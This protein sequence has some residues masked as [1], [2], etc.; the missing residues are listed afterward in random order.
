MITEAIEGKYPVSSNEVGRPLYQQELYGLLE[1]RKG[2]LV[3]YDWLL[4][5]MRIIEVF[6]SL[7]ADK[8]LVGAEVLEKIEEPDASVINLEFR[9]PVK[10][11]ILT[12]ELKYGD[13]VKK[14]KSYPATYS[15]IIVTLNRAQ[16]HAP[17]L[18]FEHVVTI[19][20]EKRELI[21]WATGSLR[22][23]DVE[24]AIYKAFLNPR[25]KCLQEEN[26]QT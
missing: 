18:D 10:T 4:R 23:V 13:H 9:W 5:Q 26:P 19:E 17:A 15:S 14:A 21:R 16:H 25:T 1:E 2:N 20:G 12:Q 8:S 3:A 11:D 24:S 7:R 22:P 6:E